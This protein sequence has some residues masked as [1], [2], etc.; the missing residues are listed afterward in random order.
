MQACDQE[1]EAALNRQQ[2]IEY[3]VS[4]LFQKKGRPLP[5]FTSHYSDPSDDSPFIQAAQSP[6]QSTTDT[7]IT[8]APSPQF[9]SSTRQSQP[10]SQPSEPIQ[11]ESDA[12]SETDESRSYSDSL[13]PVPNTQ[14]CS[15]F[16][17]KSMLV[18]RIFEL[19]QELSDERRMAQ[20]A[21]QE[22]IQYYEAL[23]QEK[24]IE[25][26]AAST[27]ARCSE[28][29]LILDRQRHR[30]AERAAGVSNSPCGSS[31]GGGGHAPS[32]GSSSR[33]IRSVYA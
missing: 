21:Q 1:L 26:A 19:E 17:D 25:L 7:P 29:E 32:P 9:L 31:P 27:P 30:L 11:P 23:L 2:Q 33:P 4:S 8:I 10:Q 12:E 14:E 22:L 16:D 20:T 28:K 13:V 6:F 3:L 5:S 15:A 18:Q 24:E